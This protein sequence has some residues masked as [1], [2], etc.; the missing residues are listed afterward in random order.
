MSDFDYRTPLSGQDFIDDQN[1]GKGCL[2]WS[3]AIIVGF[4]VTI[5]YIF[6]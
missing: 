6:I 5:I 4:I 2:V 1:A 3:L